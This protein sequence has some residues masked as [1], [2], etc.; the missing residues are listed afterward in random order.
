MV[1]AAQARVRMYP[2]AVILLMLA[3]SASA[4]L[5]ITSCQGAMAK[6]AKIG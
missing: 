4:E 1:A 6:I 3:G 2:A 5:P